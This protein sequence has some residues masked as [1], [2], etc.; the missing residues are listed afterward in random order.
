MVRNVLIMQKKSETDALKTSPKRVIQKTAETIGDLIC[1]NIA[2][3]ITKVLK[4]SQQNI[5]ETV[6]NE[7]DKE[8]PKERYVS[9]EESQ[10]II[11]ELTLK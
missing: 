6:S 1:N 5:S 3:R 11:D 4:N 10:E 8:I 9:P 7:H 2:N